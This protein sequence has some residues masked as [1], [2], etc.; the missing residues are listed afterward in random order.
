MSEFKAKNITLKVF[1]IS[2]LI[3]I[4]MCFLIFEIFQKSFSDVGRH[5][6]PK[7]VVLTL[8]G[9]IPESAKGK[10]YLT[11][12]GRCLISKAPLKI[13]SESELPVFSVK[14]NYASDI[15]RQISE[16]PAE[17]VKFT[18]AE[19]GLATCQNSPKIIYGS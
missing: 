18:G 19:N 2:H 9:R 12:K 6:D 14:M 7:T 4:L 13:L 5:V 10:V 16:L 8:A 11:H 17:E 1:W 15:L 3:S